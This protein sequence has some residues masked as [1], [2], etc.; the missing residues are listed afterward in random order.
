MFNMMRYK[1]ENKMKQED[2]KRKGKD[3]MAYVLI[4]IILNWMGAGIINRFFSPTPIPL[5]YFLLIDI[6]IAL[7]IGFII[8]VGVFIIALIIYSY[9]LF[10]SDAD[11]RREI[12]DGDV[13]PVLVIKEYKK[14]KKNL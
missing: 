1:I 14:I 4:Y 7:L 13:N 12:I 10:I 11:L 8:K 9:A 6:I 5:K 2:I 3:I